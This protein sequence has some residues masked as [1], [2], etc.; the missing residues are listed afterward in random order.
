MKSTKLVVHGVVALFVLGAISG[1]NEYSKDAQKA[2]IKRPTIGKENFENQAWQMEE[3]YW[4]YVAKMDTVAYKKLWHKDFIG[5][6]SFGDGVSGKSKIAIWIPEL[7]QDSSLKF[8]YR[9]Y[10]KA[11]NSIDDVVLAFYD[12]DWIWTD[13]EDKVVRKVTKKVTHT[14]KKYGDTWLILGGMAAE[15][16]QDVLKN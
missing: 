1:C 14:W 13:R 11:V 9:L 5:Y 2:A 15:K 7:H 16:N 12:A 4:D 10:K 3:Q 8:S 6:P